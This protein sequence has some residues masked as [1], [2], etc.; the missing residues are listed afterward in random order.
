M[1]LIF[2]RHAEPDY[3]HNCLTEKGCR[4]A[5]ILCGRQHQSIHVGERTAS[6][7]TGSPLGRE[8]EKDKR[9]LEYHEARMKELSK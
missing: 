3:Q 8:I 5:E 6:V 2:I 9:D 4:E 1:R 7:H